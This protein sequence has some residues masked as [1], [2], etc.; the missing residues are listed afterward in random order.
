MS[1][2][3]SRFSLIKDRLE[4]VNETFQLRNSNLDLAFQQLLA[5]V[6][7]VLRNYAS[8]PRNRVRS[9]VYAFRMLINMEN[10]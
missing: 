2:S 5:F 9:R 6:Q 3:L 10:Y 8:I 4:I 7:C 1:I